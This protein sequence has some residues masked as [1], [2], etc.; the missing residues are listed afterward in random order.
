MVAIKRRGFPHGASA[1]GL[2][3]LPPSHGRTR[4]LPSK[5]ASPALNIPTRATPAFEAII[6]I[7]RGYLR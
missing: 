5:Y 1:S 7:G 6:Q 2:S 3:S 4:E